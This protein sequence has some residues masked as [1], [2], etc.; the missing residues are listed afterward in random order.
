MAKYGIL[1]SKN[2][3]TLLDDCK[4]NETFRNEVIAI[5]ETDTYKFFTSYFDLPDAANEH[6]SKIGHAAGWGMAFSTDL[7]LGRPIMADID[8]PSKWEFGADKIR[9]KLDY[10]H[11]HREE[12]TSYWGITCRIWWA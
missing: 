9:M 5:L 10:E 1:N 6:L 11:G 4:N 3:Q 7:K 12:C 2:F 8:D